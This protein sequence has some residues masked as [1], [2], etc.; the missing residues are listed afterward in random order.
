VYPFTLSSS[1]AATLSEDRA[2]TLALS[3][4]VMSAFARELTKTATTAGSTAERFAAFLAT[5]EGKTALKATG[6]LAGGA[7]LGHIGHTAIK[8]YKRGRGMR[9]QHEYAYHDGGF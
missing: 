3:P 7:L 5:P 4:A 9:L 1:K 8:D 2:M 6:L